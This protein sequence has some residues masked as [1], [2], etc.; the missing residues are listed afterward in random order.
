MWVDIERRYR[1]FGAETPN[2]D[3]SYLADQQLPSHK[4]QTF[5]VLGDGSSQMY[6][7]LH[8]VEPYAA[9]LGQYRVV[10]EQTVASQNG[11]S[12]VGPAPMAEWMTCRDT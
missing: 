3:L 12:L 4:W 6:C 8:A 2:I 11:Y 1:V 7:E 5:C 9:S 10:D